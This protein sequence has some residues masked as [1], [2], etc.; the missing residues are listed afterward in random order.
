MTLWQ[1]PSNKDIAFHKNIEEY[2]SQQSTISHFKTPCSTTTIQVASVYNCENPI[3]T[4]TG[5]EQ[6]C[7]NDSNHQLLKNTI[8]DGFPTRRQQLDPKISGQSH[9]YAQLRNALQKHFFLILL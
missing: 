7:H 9:H 4:N 3:I 6:I 8:Q 2:I 1:Q 5:L